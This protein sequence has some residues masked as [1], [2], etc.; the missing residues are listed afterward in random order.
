[1]K[2][3]LDFYITKKFILI[4]ATVMICFVTV[5]ILVDLIENVQKFITRN[6]SSK[7]ILKYYLFTLPSI[8]SVALPISMLISTIFTFGDL[9]KNN[10][11]T[12]FKSSGI[13][14]F[15]ISF[16]LL[17]IGLIS[18][19][20]LFLFDNL[21]VSE[22]LQKRYDIDK[23]LKPYKKKFSRNSK[24]DIYYKLNNS[25]LEIK[26]FNY[27][28]NTGYLVS[29]KNN[30]NNDINYRLDSKKMIWRED[31]LKWNLIDC[32]MRIWD[33]GSYK[34]SEIPDTL[35][36]IFSL[37][38]TKKDSV[39]LTPEFIK[40]DIV[41]PQ[42]M[43]Y[44]E[45]DSFIL[46]LKTLKDKGIHK[47][48]VNKHYKT[49]FSFIPFIMILFGIALSIQKNKGSYA[50]GMG[51]SLIVIFLYMV[52]IRFG[53]TLGYNQILSPFL[54]VWFVNFL[55]LAIGILLIIKVKT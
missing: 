29:I 51:L 1:M 24:S 13:S 7:D 3:I 49:A 32:N 10:E 34:F 11:I 25:F 54:S 41:K 28:N 46:K 40:K 21:I 37:S 22:Y 6:L 52:I 39:F 27:K 2:K 8:L 23:K 14:I 33:N 19:L 36:R 30:I 43:N 48:E 38:D 50:K 47:W 9:Q 26:K 18:C 42:E 12:A 20:I 5:F 55:F 17:T 35:I 53:Q 15:R 44:W 16:P 4:L 31:L 45:L